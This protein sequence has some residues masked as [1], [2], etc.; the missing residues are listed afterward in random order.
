MSKRNNSSAVLGVNGANAKAEPL[1]RE[2]QITSSLL[3]GGYL[4][5]FFGW[6][7]FGSGIL[8]LLNDTIAPNT[9][10]P[11]AADLRMFYAGCFLVPSWLLQRFSA[12]LFP[13][14][15]KFFKAVAVKGTLS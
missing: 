13:F 8:G 11:S 3:L 15:M 5:A 1:E 6:A 2:P 4:L 12:G 10:Q 9:P 14:S 7:V